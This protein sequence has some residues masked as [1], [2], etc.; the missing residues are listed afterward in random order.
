MANQDDRLNIYPT[1]PSPDKS[2]VLRTPLP[3]SST[4]ADVD[5]LRQ[6]YARNVPQYRLGPLAG[7]V[8]GV[9]VGSSGTTANVSVPAPTTTT[10]VSSGGV[11]SGSAGGD[12][13]GNYPNPEVVGVNNSP[14]PTSKD[15]VGTNSNGQLIA[16]VVKESDL[17][18]SDVTTDNVSTAQHGFV[19]K[20]PN[21]ATQFFN[22]TG[23]FSA[24]PGTVTQAMSE[25]SLTNSAR[26]FASTFQNTTGVPIL[27]MASVN[28]TAANTV[29]QGI[30]DSSNPPT[31]V[32]VNKSTNSS[33]SLNNNFIVFL[34]KN[35]D[36][37][38]VT[39]SNGVLGAWREFKLLK[40]SFT[41]SGDLGPSG[42]NS[43]SL[44]TVFQNTGGVCRFVLVQVASVNGSSAV[45]GL[46]DVNNPPTSVVDDATHTSGVAETTTVL[47]VVPPN[48]FYKVTAASGSLAF[49]FE[50]DWGVT[51]TKSIDLGIAASFQNA[52]DARRAAAISQSE[53]ISTSVATILDSQTY[54][55]DSGNAMWVQVMTTNTTAA[56][57]SQLS[58]GS[59]IPATFSIAHA[60]AA[61]VMRNLYGPVMNL[62]HYS[63]FD[64]TSGNLSVNHW[65]EY[66]FS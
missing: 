48:H 37:Y 65:W 19:P 16:G 25:I 11:P 14:V 21:D 24:P 36:F 15:V 57:Y 46:S 6:F 58:S 27:V 53:N 35:N 5:A 13:G 23:V 45:Q 30:T 54:L 1:S 38:K 2:T 43:R 22:G 29:V 3:A 41:A 42:A 62:K 8:G 60:Q 26:A 55:N 32:V 44:T 7:S 66:F 39:E 56:S 61:S 64:T 50:Y 52:T 12:L 9:S 51:V 10:V 49:W 59:G 31:T 34:V 47:M 40:G 33:T 20:L 4:P 28:S 17:S 18:L 63:V